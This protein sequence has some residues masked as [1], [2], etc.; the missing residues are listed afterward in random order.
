[1]RDGVEECLVKMSEGEL[2]LEDVFWALGKE[3]RTISVVGVCEYERG[4]AGDADL[5]V[6]KK[7]AEIEILLSVKKMAFWDEDLDEERWVRKETGLSALPWPKTEAV[8]KM[9]RKSSSR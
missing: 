2:L 5:L 3:N 4:V 8:K 6:K 7:C 9:Q 1:M